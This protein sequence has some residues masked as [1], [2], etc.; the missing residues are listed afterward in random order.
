MV[1]Y[2]V[3]VQAMQGQSNGFWK[4]GWATHRRGGRAPEA[5]SP[6]GQGPGPREQPYWAKIWVFHTKGFKAQLGRGRGYIPR[7]CSPPKRPS[8]MVDQALQQSQSSRDMTDLTWDCRS[9][10]VYNPAKERPRGQSYGEDTLAKAWGKSPCGL[11]SP[12]K[13]PG[14]SGYSIPIKPLRGYCCATVCS[15]TDLTS[16]LHCCNWDDGSTVATRSED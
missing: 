1:V 16:F 6:G 12:L 4:P 10:R 15:S 2:P 7:G 8:P 13:K 14:K 11:T 9:P 5:R 3:T